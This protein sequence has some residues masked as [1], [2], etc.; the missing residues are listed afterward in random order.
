MIYASGKIVLG[1]ETKL[2][3][4]L[5][6]L[7]TGTR[8]VGLSLNSPGGDLEEGF[9]LAEAVREQHLPAVVGQGATCASACFNVFAA[10]PHRFAGSTA[11]IGVHGA[12]FRGNDEV[13]AEA[14]TVKSARQ[15]ADDGVPEA[16]LGKMITTRPEQVWWLSRADLEAMH[17]DL[18]VPH[19]D[20]KP[21]AFDPTPLGPSSPQASAPEPAI[22]PGFRVEPAAR[23][24]QLAP[25]PSGGFRVWRPG[26]AE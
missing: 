18:N 6:A 20:S 16:I 7:P 13:F 4:A 23:G 22:K 10:S 2:R 11:L 19:I 14:M 1:D 9:R 15:L 26:S 12:S 8:L 21:T 5:G 24:Y 17:V 25:P 3:A